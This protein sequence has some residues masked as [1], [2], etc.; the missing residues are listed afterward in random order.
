VPN[1]ADIKV[2]NRTP[3][4]TAADTDGLASLTPVNNPNGTPVA[5]ASLA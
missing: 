5:N 2:P 3:L 4:I 1:T